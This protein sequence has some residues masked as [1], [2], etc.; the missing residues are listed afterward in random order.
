MPESESGERAIVF[1]NKNFVGLG[2]FLA[3]GSYDSTDLSI[4]NDAVCSVKVP[5]G[6]VVRLY[7]HWHFQGRHLDVAQDTPDLG[8]WARE[9]SSAVVYKSADHPPEITKIVLYEGPQMAGAARVVGP[10]NFPQE[11]THPQVPLGSALIPDGMVLRVYPDPVFSP[12]LDFTDYFSDIM[13]LGPQGVDKY[14]W[15]AYKEPG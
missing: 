11:E 12:V 10:F 7:E 5:S 13:D 15:K 14:S 3:E 1:A 9:A 6:L 8:G 2:Q 4:G